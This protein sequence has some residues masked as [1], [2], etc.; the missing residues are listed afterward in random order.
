MGPIM[1]WLLITA[2]A[3]GS[4]KAIMLLQAKARGLSA[5]LTEAHLKAQTLDRTIQQL[6][7]QLTSLNTERAKL[8]AER[9]ALAADRDNLITQIKNAQNEKE[10]GNTAR[11][12]LGRVSRRLVQENKALKERLGPLERQNAELQRG[13]EK[14]L[15]DLAGAQRQ[16][17]ALQ[18]QVKTKQKSSA[19]DVLTKERQ[20]HRNDLAALRRAEQQVKTLHAREAAA[21]ANLNKTTRRVETL[22]EQYAAL[23][24][25]SMALRHQAKQMPV[26]ISRMAH[27][28]E[29][30]VKETADM[31]YNLGVLFSSK[32]EYNRA[33]SEF[34]KVIELRPDDADAHYNLGV[35]YAEHVPDRQK[36]MAYF[37]RYIELNPQAHDASWVKQYIASWQVWEAKE[38]L[39]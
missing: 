4:V 19:D 25:E 39:E 37:R 32:K 18:Q 29:R 17:D 22:K 5:H 11:D 28:H 33:A 7:D 16:L 36:A 30:L 10:V 15:R 3:I 26:A 6:N 1:P 12:L 21:Q 34:Q 27:Q 2:I 24:A 8:Q 14:S 31:H 20:A 38:R 9:Q 35:I 13:H 23:L